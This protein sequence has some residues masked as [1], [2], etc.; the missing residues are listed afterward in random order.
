MSKRAVAKSSANIPGEFKELFGSPALHKAED[1]KIYNAI[2]C[3][4]VKDFGPLDTI[5][6]VLLLD[7]TH[8]TYEIQRLRRLRNELIR[9]VHKQDLSRR[10]EKLIAEAQDRADHVTTPS[11]SNRMFPRWTRPPPNNPVRLKSTRFRKNFRRN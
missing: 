6:C 4:Y 9:E 2:L 10:S 5:S 8:Y 11:P 3:A 1:E 7:L